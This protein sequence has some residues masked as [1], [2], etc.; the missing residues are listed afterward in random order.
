[1]AWKLKVF[2][3]SEIKIRC[4]VLQPD[5]FD[6][7]KPRTGVSF[8]AETGREGLQVTM[9]QVVQKSPAHQQ[10][11]DEGE[12]SISP[13]GYQRKKNQASA[14]DEGGKMFAFIQ[15]SAEQHMKTLL[16]DADIQINGSRPWDLFLHNDKLF[17]RVAA[18]GSLGLGEAYMDGWWD[19]EE[20]DTF[21]FKLLSAKVDQKIKTS[22]VVIANVIK[23]TLFNRQNS[24]KAYEVGEKHYDAGND[25]F[26]CM[27]DS[28]MT[29]SCGFWEGAADLE[30]A[31]EKKLDMICRKLMLQPGMKLLDIGCGWGSL[32][33]YAAEQY[34]VEAVGLTIS[35]E[36]ASL[37]GKQCESLPVEIRLQDYREVEG[38]FDAVV[39]VGMFEHV[40]YK[41]YQTFMDVVRS[42]LKEEGLFLL[43]T[44]A[45]NNS[46]RNCDIWFDKY[47]FPNGMLP[48]IR[49]LGDAMEDRFVMED[50]HNIGAD[51]DAT[52]C[53][54]YNNFKVCWP[55]LSRNYSERFYRMWRYYLLSLAG[56]FRA[57][58]M[59]VW[60]VVM[61]P[62][63][64]VGGY[65][66]NRWAE[67]HS[68]LQPTRIA[69]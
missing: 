61:S 47:I 19:C 45:S 50:W 52:L 46:M 4:N 27:L 23:S 48:S 9:V 2:N 41:N 38:E 29:Y 44:I 33:Q 15:N 18:Y 43:H 49:Q 26:S 36:Q 66:S 21:F 7:L 63:G 30:E 40:G 56:G 32:V 12:E 5:N 24:R 1:M 8:T 42:C 69:A 13:F 17:D 35:K 20:M 58:S 65:P 11:T 39:S 14:L 51:Y 34:G 68:T 16:A 25:L 10:L 67:D 28:R 6:D 53:A 31:Q 22:P 37:A 55:D 64:I 59:Q 54:W 57:R 3:D 60:Q 62:E